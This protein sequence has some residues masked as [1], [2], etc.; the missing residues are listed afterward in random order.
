MSAK[1]MDNVSIASDGIDTVFNVENGN[2]HVVTFG[3]EQRERKAPFEFKFQD[4]PVFVVEEPDA[5][6]V[7]DIEDARV[8][9]RVLKLFLGEQYDDVMD[10]LGAERP[11][12]LLDFTQSISQHFGLFDADQAVN[13]AERRGRNR[14]RGRKS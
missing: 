6:T 3:G 12:V 1:N 11:E 8:T 5:D 14:R 4:S 2:G 7:M 13:R 10:Y 9:R